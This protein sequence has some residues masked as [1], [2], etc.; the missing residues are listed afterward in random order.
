MGLLH[1]LEC[2]VGLKKPRKRKAKKQ[3]RRKAEFRE[4]KRR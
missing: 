4:R 2:A 3:A 1:K